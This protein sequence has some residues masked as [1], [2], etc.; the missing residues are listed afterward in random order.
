MPK[1]PPPS[2]PTSESHAFRGSTSPYRI[3]KDGGI[4]EF[5]S[6]VVRGQGLGGGPSI[7]SAEAFP[8]I[9]CLLVE[10]LWQAAHTLAELEKSFA[11]PPCDLGKIVRSENDQDHR[12]NQNHFPSPEKAGEHRR[13]CHQG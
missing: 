5:G 4:V 1:Q 11:H 7:N 8:S 3:V 9:V 2:A 13:N 6:L 12:K 10:I